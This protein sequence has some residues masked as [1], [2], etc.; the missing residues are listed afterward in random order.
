MS[1]L[2]SSLNGAS[3]CTDSAESGS[4]VLPDLLEWKDLISGDFISL[5]YEV[6]DVLKLTNLVRS[7]R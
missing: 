5:T 1:E 2:V 4:E 7:D 6:I 3:D